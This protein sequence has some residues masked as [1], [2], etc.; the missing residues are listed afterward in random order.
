MYTYVHNKGKCMF[1][2]ESNYPSQSD[3]EL[4]SLLVG[5]VTKQDQLVLLLCHKLAL[6]VCGLLVLNVHSTGAC[7]S[8]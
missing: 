1:I 7:Q 2:C 4:P 6:Q 5:Q 3:A 8:I